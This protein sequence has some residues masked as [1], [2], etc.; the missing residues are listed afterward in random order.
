MGSIDIFTPAEKAIEVLRRLEVDFFDVVVVY[1][2][3]LSI[4]I[5][6][7]GIKEANSK[8]NVGLS[9][10]VFKNKGLGVAYTQSLD[11][12]DVE[13]TARRAVKYARVAQ[14]NPHFKGIPGPSKAKN[15]QELCDEEIVNLTLEDASR[16]PRDMINACESV[17]SG[18]MYRG[19]FNA[20]Y[21]KLRLVTS[22]GVD[23]EDDKTVASASIQ[24]VY[25]S[26]GD[27]GSSYEFDYSVYLSD[28]NP[29]LVGRRAAGKAVEQFGSKKIKS[30]VLP[31]ILLPEASSTLFMSLF[32]ALS[33]EEA[34]KGRTF[35]SNLLGKQVAPENLEVIDDGTIP[36]AVASSTYDGEGV[37]RRAV[38]VIKAGTILTFLHNSYSAGIMNVESTGHAIR[39]G[40]KGY[41]SAGP[42]NVRV[43]PGDST[44]NEILEETR[45]GILVTS[46]SFSPNMVSGEISTT[47]DE[48]FLIENGKKA[49]PVKNLMIGGNVLDLLKCIDLISK[50]GRVFGGGHFFPAIRI[51]EAKLSGE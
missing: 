10:R 15:I 32:S 37:P 11:E 21:T 7:R 8:V 39:D 5:F 42:S 43:K 18:G 38:E 36:R 3:C 1:S 17:R 28:I 29:Q 22:T 20:R 45:R 13:E 33:G 44:L 4:N 30:E 12:N 40:Y 31:L 46:A 2:R 23:I 24:S 9:V 47:V 6:G 50:E 27:V 34:V 35:A 41:I 16:I 14:P 19:G 48:G 49:F 25:R 26:G 51:K